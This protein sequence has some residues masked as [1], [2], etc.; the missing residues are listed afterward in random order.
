MILHHDAKVMYLA[1]PRT[2]SVATE[3]ALKDVGFEWAPQANRHA[4]VEDNAWW[5]DQSDEYKEDWEILTTVRNPYDALVTWWH[6][7]DLGFYRL[8]TS[9]VHEILKH[10]P[11]YMK[12]GRLFALHGYDA[13]HILR[14]ETLEKDLQKASE[15]FGFSSPTLQVH[16]KTEKRNGRP[17]QKYYDEKTRQYVRWALHEDFEDFGYE[18]EEK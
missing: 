4:G 3:V 12:D 15:I 9:W 10:D 1:H 13:T 14:Y 18:W 16:N 11:K 7:R 17:Y 8:T 5:R 6:N 2:A